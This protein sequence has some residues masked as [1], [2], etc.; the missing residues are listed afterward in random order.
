MQTHFKSRSSIV[1]LGT[2]SENTRHLDNEQIMYPPQPFCFAAKVTHLMMH[3]E[4]LGL[5]VAGPTV[6]ECPLTI[7][8]RAVTTRRVLENMTGMRKDGLCEGSFIPF[9]SVH[10]A[11]VAPYY[12]PCSWQW[13]S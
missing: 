9:H 13:P 5:G 3:G 10:D 2:W 1:G 4:M 6:V 8:A 7:T 11:V 12:I